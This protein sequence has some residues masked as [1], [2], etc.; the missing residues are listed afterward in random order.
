MKTRLQSPF[1]TEL[2]VWSTTFC[3]SMVFPEKTKSHFYTFTFLTTISVFQTRNSSEK[4]W[5]RNAHTWILQH[6]RFRLEERRPSKPPQ[7]VERRRPE[8]VLLRLQNCKFVQPASSIVYRKLD[9]F[10]RLADRHETLSWKQRPRNPKI[11]QQID[12]WRL[13]RI[14]KGSHATVS[15]PSQSTHNWKVIKKFS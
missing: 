4:V 14:P 5:Q 15:G 2:P 10:F 1:L 13:A 11:H 3:N 9:H 6:E 8:K 12:W 7:W